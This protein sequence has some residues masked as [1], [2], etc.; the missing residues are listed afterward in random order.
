MKTIDGIVP[1]FKKTLLPFSLAFGAASFMSCSDQAGDESLKP[2]VVFIQIDDLGWTDLGFMG[3]EYYETPNVDE[4]ASE[5]LMFTNAYA[6]ASNSAP[7]R[8]NLLTG[9]NSPRHGVYTVSPSAR[10]DDRTRQLIPIENT[11]SI[12]PDMMTLGHLFKEKGYTNCAI[13]KWHLSEDPRNNGFHYNI[14][15]DL[16]GNPGYPT[17]YFAPY[18]ISNIEQGPEGEYLTDRLTD[19]AITFI[20]AHHEQPF[21]LYMSYYTVHTPLEG[22]EHLV[23]KYRKKET[24]Q[25]H[26]HPVY[27][28]MIESMDLNVG[29]ILDK[30]DSLD[31][32][33]NTIVIF[34][35][36]NGGIRGISRQDPLRAGKGSYYEGGIRVPMI[37]RWPG[38]INEGVTDEPVT[39]LD[40]FPTFMRILDV[41]PEDK[42]LDGDDLSPL[43]D[44]GSL[45]NRPLY[46][47]FP[48]YLQEFAGAEDQARDPLF[49]TRPGSAMRY[50]EWKLHEFFE[51]GVIELY[52]LENDPGEKTNVADKHPEITDKLFQMLVDWRI[53]TGA[54]IPFARNPMYDA[55]FE[56]SQIRE[57]SAQVHQDFATQKPDEFRKMLTIMTREEKW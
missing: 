1:S 7:S 35:S 31:L 25:E 24:T 4:L 33:Q 12:M 41:A 57:L 21:F 19:E 48:V 52:N 29:R 43:F 9:M 56:Q 5:G 36:D 10:G 26:H 53:D 32:A 42:I 45:E 47:H 34:I 6:G 51:D 3:S 37:M 18:S 46:W 20:E 39:N 50:G 22:K 55:A 11:D 15:G 38:H 40:F 28:A 13:G 54:K 44:G 27:A 14:G 30:I 16:R 49:R 23:E 8:A 2:N 17:G